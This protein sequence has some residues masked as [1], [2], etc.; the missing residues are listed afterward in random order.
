[1]VLRW[2]IQRN[3]II[4]PKS[5]SVARMRENFEIF[6][7]DLSQEEM[8]R[9]GALNRNQRVGPDPDTFAPAPK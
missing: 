6:D 4:F 9:I 2:H 8:D 1:V 3:S 7:F 5:M